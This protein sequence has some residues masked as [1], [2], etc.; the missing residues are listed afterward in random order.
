M[1]AETRSGTLTIL[2]TDLVG[3]TELMQ[4]L[5]DDAAEDLRRAHFHLL[6]EAVSSHHGREVKTIGDSFMVAFNSAVDAVACAVEIQQAVRKYNED[7]GAGRLQVR[8]GLHAGEPTAAEDD[9]FGTPVVVARR[10]C[11]SARGGQVLTSALVRGLV[12]SRGGFRF[13][14]IGARILKGID[15]PVQTYEVVWEPA[16]AALPA[17]AR[18]PRWAFV[19]GALASAGGIAGVVALAVLLADGG[20]SGSQ[21]GGV[22]P[23][24][25]APGGGRV[26]TELA[27]VSDRGG[28]LAIH[29]VNTDGSGRTSLPDIPGFDADLAWSPDGERIAFTAKQTG[30]AQSP[31]GA[32]PDTGGGGGGGGGGGRG[33]QATAQ[34]TAQQQA[35]NRDVFVINADGSG[36]TQ[37]TADAAEDIEPTWS[38]D[39]S[40]IAF[41]SRRDG[42]REI[43]VMNADGTGQTRLTNDPADDFHPDWSPAGDLIAFTSTRTGNREVFTMTSGGLEPDAVTEHDADDSQ[44]AWSPDG[45]RL[46]FTSTRDGTREVYTVNADGSGLSRLTDD[47]DDDF[48]A[49]WSPD[50]ER[51]AFTKDADGNREIWV[52]NVDGTGLQQVT[53]DAAQDQ[54]PVWAPAR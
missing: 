38:P 47:R 49:A 21:A 20:D 3:S 44:P 10:L 40:R 35:E 53:E 12:G 23:T 46:A 36:L 30:G 9:L 27:F 2:F 41:T 45:A 43:Y 32:T 17:A 6:R 34:A 8:I 14:D 31:S 1:M 24:E 16:A 37:L 25:Q 26:T 48:N 13:A 19:G 33:G 11:D 54:Q 15:E 28:V 52:I 50:G 42:N 7:G 51:I 5:G 39:G 29:F 18:L 22:T 4:R